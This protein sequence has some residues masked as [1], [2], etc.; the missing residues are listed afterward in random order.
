MDLLD[1]LACVHNGPGRGPGGEVL[2]L[3]DELGPVLLSEVK[4]GD[5]DTQWRTL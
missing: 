3:R 4:P 2:Q 1:V 5:V